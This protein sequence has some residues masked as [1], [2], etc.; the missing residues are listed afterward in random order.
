MYPLAI[1][2]F[3]S[4]GYGWLSIIQYIY[5]II[6]NFY[7]DSKGLFNSKCHGCLREEKPLFFFQGWLPNCTNSAVFQSSRVTFLRATAKAHHWIHS[8]NTG[9]SFFVTDQN[10]GYL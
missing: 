2:Y 9:L 6:G 1:E 5:N 10:Y 8:W 7:L 4:K 3:H